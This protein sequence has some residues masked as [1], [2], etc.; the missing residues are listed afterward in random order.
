[1]KTSFITTVY[2]EEKTIIPFLESIAC[3]TQLPTE[4]IIVD[5][6]S[7]DKTVD[8]IKVYRSK[9]KKKNISLKIIIKEGNRSVG[10]NEAIKKAGYDTIL[11]SDSGCI[12]EKD[13]IKNITKPFIFKNTSVVSGFYKPVI[14]NVF[15]KCLAAYTCV[16]EQKLNPDTFLPSSRSVAF[17][18]SAW[19]EVGGFPE[20][21][22]TC[23]DLVFDKKLKEKDYIFIL[24]KNAVVYWPQRKNVWEAFLQFFCYAR[25]DGYAHYF[26]PQTPTLFLRYVLGAVLLIDALALQSAVLF[27]LFYLAI[28]LYIF[29]S[30]KK[31]YFYIKNYKAIFFLPLLQFISDASVISGT[32]LG[33]L[34]SILQI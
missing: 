25:G 10:R 15:Q 12:L 30:I 18:K 32:I 20:N 1:M 33:F 11:C 34:Q 22:S 26:R 5:A 8:K 23:E 14:K 28:V 7:K 21:L 9:F 16:P 29:W 6:K 4:V 2:N 31:N 3:Q 27:Y 19:K 13:W 24:V 17:K